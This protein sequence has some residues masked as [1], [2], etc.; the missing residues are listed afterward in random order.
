MIIHTWR[1]RQLQCRRAFSSKFKVSFKTCFAPR[2]A[3]RRE[4]FAVVLFL[5]RHSSGGDSL[6]QICFCLN[7]F[8]IN[9]CLSSS[10]TRKRHDSRIECLCPI[11]FKNFSRWGKSFCPTILISSKYAEKNSCDVRWTRR[12]SQVGTFLQSCFICASS[13][14]HSQSSP[15]KGWP[16]KFLFCLQ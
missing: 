16:N 7:S 5:V 10:A 6:K 8:M 1:F 15:A 3:R 13:H 12:H 2:C 9:F 14:L 11:L 4:M